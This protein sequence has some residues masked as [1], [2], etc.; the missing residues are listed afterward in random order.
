MKR[1]F[2]M[3]DEYRIHVRFGTPELLNLLVTII[4]LFRVGRISNIAS[5]IDKGFRSF[6]EG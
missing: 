1:Y 2:E 5:E 3:Y 4:L 6:G